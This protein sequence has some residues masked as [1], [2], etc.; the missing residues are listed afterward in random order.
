MNLNNIKIGLR[1]GLGFGVV[2]LLVFIVGAIG[3]WG[4][5]SVSDV[6][7]NIVKTEVVMLEKADDI[8]SSIT[9]MCRFEKNLCQEVFYG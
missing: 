7:L 9:G 1:L 2:I 8:L 5:K 6:L 3:H 4:L